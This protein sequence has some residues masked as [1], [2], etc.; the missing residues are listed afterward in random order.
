MKEG[1]GGAVEQEG[2]V[3]YGLGFSSVQT[4]FFNQMANYIN[5]HF[6]S[7]VTVVRDTF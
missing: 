4:I 2:G 7:N 6:L 5:V 3:V 1:G